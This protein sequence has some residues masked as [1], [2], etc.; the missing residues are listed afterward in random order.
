MLFSKLCVGLLMSFFLKFNALKSTCQFCALKCAWNLYV[1][2]YILSIMKFYL[3]NTSKWKKQQSTSITHHD[4][5]DLQLHNILN[6]FV[7]FTLF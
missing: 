1:K 3:Q 5:L 2:F 4:S 7:T 6:N